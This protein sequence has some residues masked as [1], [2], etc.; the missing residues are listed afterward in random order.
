MRSKLLR[1]GSILF[2]FATFVAV[3]APSVRAADEEPKGKAEG[4]EDGEKPKKR[5][6][7]AAEGEETPGEAAKPKGEGEGDEDGEKPKKRKK[8]KDEGDE[9]EGAKPAKAAPVVDETAGLKEIGTDSVAA[10]SPLG[11][12]KIDNHL[13]TEVGKWGWTWFGDS[14]FGPTTPTGGDIKISMVGVRNWFSPKMGWEAGTGLTVSKAA[15]DGAPTNVCWG[16]TGGVLY[17]LARY[18]YV[19]VFAAG[20]AVLVPYCKPTGDTTDPVTNNKT[21]PG[22]IF[23]FGVS[24]EVAV[25]IFLDAFQPFHA[26][27]FLKTSRSM[28]IT[29]GSGLSIRYTKIGDTTFTPGDGSASTSAG[30]T[31]SMGVNTTNVVNGVSNFVGSPTGSV[32]FTYYF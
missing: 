31:S 24:G 20:R 30:A 13:P 10:T 12:V 25:E 8:K 14:S 27:P 17:S 11:R 26:G 6:K 28:S 21:S 15:G 4:D 29:F 7:K 16:F 9:E 1:S 22:S 23:Q 19:N 2:A 3:I 18:E 32:A 5:K